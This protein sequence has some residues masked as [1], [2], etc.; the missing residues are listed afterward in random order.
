VQDDPLR[1]ILYRSRAIRRPDTGEILEV[2]KRNNGMDGVTGILLFDG[3]AFVQVLEGPSS[4]VAACYERIR[5][6]PRH[7]DVTILSDIELE[8]RE[9]PYWSMEMRDA[10]NLSDD[11][12]FRLQRRL[13]QLAPDLKRHFYR[14]AED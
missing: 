14:D 10:R 7:T 6:D 5:T 11:S 3:A 13:E 1:Q 2:S 4:S 9:F 8:E 12:D